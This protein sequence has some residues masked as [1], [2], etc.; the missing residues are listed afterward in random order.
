MLLCL[1]AGLPDQR[2]HGVDRRAGWIRETVLVSRIVHEHSDQRRLSE[3]AERNPEYLS[4]QPSTHF[5]IESRELQT[6]LGQ[7]PAS[8]VAL[9]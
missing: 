9:V 1:V 7:P 2:G 3:N 4:F 8:N 6:V 5:F